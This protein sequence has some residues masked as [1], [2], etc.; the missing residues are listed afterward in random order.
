MVRDFRESLVAFSG[1]WCASTATK[2]LRL[3]RFCG[4]PHRPTLT[5]LMQAAGVVSLSGKVA[6][7]RKAGPP[8][9]PALSA[10]GSPAYRFRAR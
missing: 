4:C 2:T 3:R 10:S 9:G 6:G 5:A 8:P 1:A 7:Q